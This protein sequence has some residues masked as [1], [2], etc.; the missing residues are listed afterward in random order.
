MKLQDADLQLLPHQD[1]KPD[2]PPGLKPAAVLLPL[3]EAEGVDWLVFTRR[4]AHLRQ[5]SGQ[6]A[7]PGGKFD[8]EDG[9]LAW[10]A[11]RESW[12]EIGL[13]PAEVTLLGSLPPMETIS[14][15]LLY[16]IVGR[17][18]WPLDL[19]AN[20]DEIDE[21]ICVP[22]GHLADP[23]FQRREQR[24]YRGQ[25]HLIHYFDYPP[26]TIWGIT[27]QILADFLGRLP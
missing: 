21:I 12:E 5:H 23:A 8:A 6:I 13:P 22:L 19:K 9:H 20:P 4:S 1:L 3:Y 18:A 17:F 10:T 25:D 15:Y 14:D 2:T 16:P 11:L 24:H 26:H 7:F 27:G